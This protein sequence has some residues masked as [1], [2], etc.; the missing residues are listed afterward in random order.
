MTTILLVALAG[1]AVYSAVAHRHQCAHKN[2]LC[3]RQRPC[4]HCYRELF[5]SVGFMGRDVE[6]ASGLQ[7][8]TGRRLVLL[9]WR[10]L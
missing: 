6:Q 3:R 5:N 9:G 7:K 1:L 2:P 8:G 10:K 4:L